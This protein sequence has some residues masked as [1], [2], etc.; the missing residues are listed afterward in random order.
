MRGGGP[1]GNRTAIGEFFEHGEI[2][3]NFIRVDKISGQSNG[4]AMELEVSRR[5]ASTQCQRDLEVIV[6]G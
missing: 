6:D 4:R 1:G 5:M 3:V 2:Q